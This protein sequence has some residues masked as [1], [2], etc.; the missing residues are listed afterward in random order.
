MGPRWDTFLN[1]KGI[2]GQSTK[3][4]SGARIIGII[5]VANR[6]DPQAWKAL[7]ECDW[8]EFRGDF[9]EPSRI[10]SELH[11]FRSECRSRLGHTLETLFTL[12]L[13]RDGGQWLDSNAA[14][15]DKIWLSIG[16]DSKDC[17]C[18][19][20]DLELEVL[21]LLTPALKKVLSHRFVK[22]IVSHHNLISSY[23]AQELNRIGH[24]L[25]SWG[26]EGQKMAV[27][28]QD[29]LEALDLMRFAREF[30]RPGKNICVLSMGL[31][32]RSTRVLGPI[33]GCPLTYG[34]LSG[35]AI[36]P[37]QLSAHQ[38]AQFFSSLA[39]TAPVHGSDSELLDW[40]EAHL[41]GDTFA[42]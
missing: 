24:E 14:D 8:V 19:W 6:H 23:P 28:C 17:P 38:L 16:L 11:S 26:Y 12:R 30:N 10:L 34:F 32:A 15:R 42:N 39:G 18:E 4:R 2:V 21:P 29:R 20:I 40:A 3:N 13:K 33:L 1:L 36:A 31:P 22:V 7:E 9:W 27:T 41:S 25:I 37:G 5:T 35:D